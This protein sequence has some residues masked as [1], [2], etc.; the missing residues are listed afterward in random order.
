MRND[1][2]HD[3]VGTG[4]LAKVGQEQ[5]QFDYAVERAAGRFDDGLH[6]G[7][8]LPHLAFEVLVHQ[9]A[10]SWLQAELAGQIDG[11]SGTAGNRLRKIG[12]ASSRAGVGPDVEISGVADSLKK[13][14]NKTTYK[15]GSTK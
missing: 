8:R 11:F 10:G 3:G 2:C 6:V 5:S 15:S 9:L 1:V 13:K 7:K 14:K 4:E 12:G